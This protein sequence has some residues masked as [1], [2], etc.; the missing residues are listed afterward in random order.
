MKKNYII[1]IVLVVLAVTASWYIAKG[2]KVAPSPS[3]TPS[4]SAGNVNKAVVSV[5]K[6]SVGYFMSDLKG[7]TLYEFG[8]DKNNISSCNDACAK[9]WPPFLYTGQ[10]WRSSSDPLTSQLSIIER[11][12]GTKQFSY[13]NKPLYY[14]NGDKTP[15]DK[16]GIST[17]GWTIIRFSGPSTSP[18]K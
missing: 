17:P 16:L 8:N 5:N 12:D 2:S 1:A 4:A 18:S 6:D 14:Y 7:M 13:A 3:N 9:M 10:D 11:A 15:G